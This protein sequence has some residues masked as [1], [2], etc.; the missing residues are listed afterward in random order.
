M[1]E[2]VFI[3]LTEILSKSWYFAL[4]ASFFWGVL[5]VVLSPCHL[6]SIPL[7]VA[8]IGGQG[9][10]SFKKAVLISLFF[11]F[12]ILLSISAIGVITGITGNILGNIGTIGNILV[13]VIFLIVG[14]H[15]IGLIPLPNWFGF[16]Q[17]KAHKKGLIA[18]FL[19]GLMFGLAL[20]PCTFAFLAPILVIGFSSA[21]TNLLFSFFII[22]IFA[23][24]HCLVFIIFGTFSELVQKYLNWN[25]NSKG[26]IIIK[27]FIG[28]IIILVGGY[29]LFNY[30]LHI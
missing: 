22:F 5:S 29:I 16:T 9:K 1:I 24:G 2:K 30:V 14:L 6:G 20:G 23:V 19:L 28:I 8:F 27:K 4:I 17:P 12:G 18:G 15:F 13:V 21:S 3:G 10:I 11:S 7:V 25:E 26:T